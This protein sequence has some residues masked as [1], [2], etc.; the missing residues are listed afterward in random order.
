MSTV[1]ETDEILSRVHFDDKGL[2]PAI[3]QQHDTLEVLMLGYMDAEALR[4]TL[5][6]GRVTFWSRSRQE[7]WRKGDTSG[8]V[9]Y[10]KTAALDCDDDTLLVQ[11]D[12]IGAACHTGARRCFD[13]DPLNPEV[14]ERS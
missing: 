2:L 13:V 1:T 6:E 8:H 11:V 14:L 9:Q 10:V 5:T 4:R 3:I 7:Y 12:Q